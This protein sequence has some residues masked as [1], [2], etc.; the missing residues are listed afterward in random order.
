[1]EKI[2]SALEELSVFHEKEM[3]KLEF[4]SG[5]LGPEQRRKR[6]I[7]KIVHLLCPRKAEIAK[8]VDGTEASLVA[9]VSDCLLMYFLN[10]A[11]PVLLISQQIAKVGLE[12]F[13]SDPE[14]LIES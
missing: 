10:L 11:A 9:T 6:I 8:V 7:E 5:S 12:R 4:G 14:S 2:K 13:C 1:M 3:S